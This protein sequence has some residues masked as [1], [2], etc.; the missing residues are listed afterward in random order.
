M[1]QVEGGVREEAEHLING[2]N[3]SIEEMSEIN[4]LNRH[5]C[6][7]ANHLMTERSKGE[8]AKGCNCD[9]FLK[10]HEKQQL[11]FVTNYDQLNII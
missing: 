11:L 5:E 10:L 9:N 4:H 6:L 8:Y 1:Q 2:S 7:Q 3:I